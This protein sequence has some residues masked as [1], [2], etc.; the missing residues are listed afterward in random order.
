MKLLSIF[1]LVA[2]LP[3][4]AQS[5]GG[6][7]AKSATPVTTGGLPRGS[8]A[9]NTPGWPTGMGIPQD[10]QSSWAAYGS[11]KATT[12]DPC[13]S[14]LTDDQTRELANMIEARVKQQAQ[15][16]DEFRKNIPTACKAKAVAYYL[17]VAIALTKKARQP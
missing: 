15:S 1:V 3:C 12:P 10:P 11:S 8:T 14:Q 6:T 7:G 4:A 16:L 9:Q 17:D 5:L 13:Y 2:A